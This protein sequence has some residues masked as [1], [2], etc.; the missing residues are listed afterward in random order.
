MPGIDGGGGVDGIKAGVG[1]GVDGSGWVS[2]EEGTM[3][4]KSLLRKA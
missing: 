3:R 2:K 1:R 4:R